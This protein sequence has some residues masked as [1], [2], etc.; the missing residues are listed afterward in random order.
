MKRFLAALLISVSVFS[1]AG[2]GKNDAKEEK[3]IAVSV[4]KA[5][6][7]DIE[8][9]NTFLGTTKIKDSTAVTVEMP[10]VVEETYVSS[11]DRVVKGQE[12][13]KMKGTDVENSI[14]TAE[15]AYNTALGAYNDSSEM[16]KSQ[17]ETNLEKAKS[18]YEAANKMYEEASASFEETEKSYEE[19][20]TSET[21]Y[22][23]AKAVVD[24]LKNNADQ[25]QKSYEAVQKAYDAGGDSEQAKAAVEQAE[26]A[27][28]VAKSN[29]DKLV[30]KAP[31]D[32]VITAKT[33]EAGETASQAQPAFIISETNVL[34]ITLSVTDSDIK[35]FSKDQ[36][37]NVKLGDEEVTG[38]VSE[39]PQVPDPAT[40]LYKVEVDV[41]NFNEKY[42]AGTAAE[43]SISIEKQTNV[44]TVPKK[45]VFE[46]DGKKYVYIVDSDNRARKKE[47]TTGIETEKDIEISGEVKLDDIIVVGGLSLISE[48]TKLFPV[49]KKED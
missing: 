28:N 5:D 12:L 18:S 9:S 6:G 20:N 29:R 37:V 7:S 25:A 3:A 21:A 14:K 49:E 1:F 41:D 42:S 44:I 33:F 38:K 24:Q 26:T 48:N 13:L 2:C 47:V 45:A 43:V 34:S 19:G 30:L 40:S 17:L 15:A 31:C 22:K 27:L 39:V 46:E 36:S 16:T 32:G 23:A 35:K 11:G 4:Q 8:N 10:G